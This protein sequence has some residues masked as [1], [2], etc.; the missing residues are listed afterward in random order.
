MT[1]ASRRIRRLLRIGEVLEEGTDE[2]GED[3]GGAQAQAQDEDGEEN[4]NRV[5]QSMAKAAEV[6]DGNK[7]SKAK[8]KVQPNKINPKIMTNLN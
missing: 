5:V 6:K 1:A 4:E 3:K 8:S 2:D 7:K